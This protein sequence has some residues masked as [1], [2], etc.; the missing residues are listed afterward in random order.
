MDGQHG[1]RQAV[2]LGSVSMLS[3]LTT[4]FRPLVKAPASAYLEAMGTIEDAGVIPDI[5]EF[6]EITR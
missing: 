6:A 4:L 5:L 2:G 3:A 1:G